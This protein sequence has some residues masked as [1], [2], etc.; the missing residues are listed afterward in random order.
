MIIA[1]LS[2]TINAGENEKNIIKIINNKKKEFFK[3]SNEKKFETQI[4]IYGHSKKGIKPLFF[5]IKK[6]ILKKPI[7]AI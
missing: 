5:T 2:F 3:R 1:S 4:K 6:L 7:D